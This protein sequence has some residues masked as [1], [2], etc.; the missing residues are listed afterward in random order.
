MVL[1][2]EL[3]F[4]FFFV[5]VTKEFC[6]NETGKGCLSKVVRRVRNC[7]NHSFYNDWKGTY[8]VIS[9]S[10]NGIILRIYFELFFY[11]FFVGVTKEFWSN[12]TGKGCLSKVVRRVRNCLNHSFYN[13]WKGTYGVISISCNGIILRIFFLIFFTFF[14]VGVTK[15]FW[16]NEIDK[17][18]LSK[19]VQRIRNY[20]NLSFYNDWIGTYGVISISCDGIIL[21]TFFLLFFFLSMTKAFWSNETGK[22][23][24]IKVF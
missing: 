21:R 13:D 3:F 23:C 15:A 16:S 24:L 4:Y 22:G 1:Y 18:C 6:S 7:L 10:C 8:G 9:I 17:R 2:F 5:G 19:V 11:F 14:F 12:E 20:S